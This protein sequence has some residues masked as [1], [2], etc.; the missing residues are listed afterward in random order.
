MKPSD[1]VRKSV[2]HDRYPRGIDLINALLLDVPWNKGIRSWQRMSGNE[3]RL[4]RLFEAFPPSAPVLVAY[5]KFLSQVGEKSLPGAFELMVAKLR[6]AGGRVALLTSEAQF[7]LESLLRRW[8]LS[9]PGKLK[10]HTALRDSVLFILDELVQAGSSLA[11]RLRD[12]F[13][14]PV[15]G[16]SQEQLEAP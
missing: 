1:E 4:D 3:A 15:S 6:Q 12:D 16:S 2:H 5:A 10:E 11:C 7:Y 13:V 14:A 8:V 9:Q